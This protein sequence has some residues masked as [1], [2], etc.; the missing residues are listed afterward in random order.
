MTHNFGHKPGKGK[1]VARAIGTGL[2]A[3]GTAMADGPKH[4]RIEAIDQEIKDL[5]QER[6]HLIA[7]L[8][9]PGS[10]KPSKDYDPNA[11]VGRIVRAPAPYSTDGRLEHCEGREY[12]G[13][14]HKAHPAC[15]YI[16][17]IHIAH[18]FTL[19]D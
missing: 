3:L 8:I 5:K 10:L 11:Y 4:A 14:Y 18:D 6:D 19:R 17:T 12:S 2:A 15:P 1:K 16:D 13:K 7:G 9:E